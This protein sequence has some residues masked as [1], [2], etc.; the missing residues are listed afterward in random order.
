MFKFISGFVF[1]LIFWVDVCGNLNF[2]IG[3]LLD[4]LMIFK[5]LFEG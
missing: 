2:L 1:Y 5:K 4:F 3:V